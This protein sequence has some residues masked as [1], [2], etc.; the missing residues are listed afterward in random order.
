METTEQYLIDKYNS[1]TLTT[2]QLAEV[3]HMK[4]KP[5]QN[6]ISA[7]RCPVHTYKIG[8]RRVADVRDVAEW[9]DRQRLS[10]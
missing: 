3:L 1:L 6:A 9:M 2:P 10:A 4:V 5:L 8:K 7:E